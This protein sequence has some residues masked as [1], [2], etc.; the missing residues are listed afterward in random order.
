MTYDLD[1]Y[2]EYDE[3]GPYFDSYAG[4]YDDEPN[5]L[6]GQE[7]DDEYWLQECGLIEGQG[8]VIAG[9]EECDCECPFSRAILQPF[10]EEH[11]SVGLLTK[12]LT[13]LRNWWSDVRLRRRLAGE[14]YREHAHWVRYAWG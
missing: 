13:P 4:C 10:Y 7:D 12:I 9:S 1:D 3:N 2:T 11:Q 8:C 6:W 14:D 5:D